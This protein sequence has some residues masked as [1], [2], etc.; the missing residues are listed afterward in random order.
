MRLTTCREIREELDDCP[1]IIL[2][3]HFQAFAIY[4]QGKLDLAREHCEQ[5]L[6]FQDEGPAHLGTIRTLRLLADIAIEKQEH[7][8][9][10]LNGESGIT[11][12]SFSRFQDEIVE[13]EYI[14]AVIYRFLGQYENGLLLLML[15]WRRSRGRE[16]EHFYHT[17]SMNAV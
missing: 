2:A 12:G 11:G 8:Q 9:A 16:N 10:E 14:M 1:G 3:R 7:M 15:P 13:I 5:A 17:R 4:R 6:A